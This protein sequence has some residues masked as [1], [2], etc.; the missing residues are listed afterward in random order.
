MPAPRKS[1]NFKK[2]KKLSQEQMDKVLPQL[3]DLKRRNAAKT[4]ELCKIIQDAVTQLEEQNTMMDAE[5]ELIQP[6]YINLIQDFKVTFETVPREFGEE[7]DDVPTT[8]IDCADLIDAMASDAAMVSDTSAD[9]ASAAT[10]AV[11]EPVAD[12]G[13]E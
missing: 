8:L 6:G 12:G 4:L 10:S 13:D 3:K 1:L 7:L 9:T 5:A 11:S 2:Q